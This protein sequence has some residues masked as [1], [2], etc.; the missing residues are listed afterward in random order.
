MSLP[1]VMLA[2]AG[3]GIGLLILAASLRRPLPSLGEAMARVTAARIPSQHAARTTR[4]GLAVALGHAV[5]LDRLLTDT[6]RRD[7]RALDRS[8][9]DQVARSLLTALEL[10]AVPPV[11]SALLAVEHIGIGV[12]LPAGVT[13]A[14]ALGGALLPTATLHA[15]AERRRRSFK[16]ALG[17][18]FNLVGVNV[19]AGKGVEGALE[20]AAAG[21]QGPA[22]A[23]IREALYRAKIAGDTPW[24]GLDRLGEDLGIA[25]LRELAATVSLAG[26]VGAKVRDSLA[27]KA[28]TL[29]SRGLAEI[30]EAANAANE[31]MSLPVVLLVVAFIVFIGYPAVFRII[32]GL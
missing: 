25:E 1:V 2:G 32:H 24:A 15:E 17:A 22:F 3:V 13:V 5:G 28:A 27:A 20:T 10:G 29:R 30:E 12:A 7:L 26:D 8:S 23:E 18:Y 31:R 9:D 4:R 21:G 16:H 14:F 11:L 19:A 6:V